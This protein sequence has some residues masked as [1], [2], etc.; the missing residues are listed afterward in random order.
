MAAA[1]HTAPGTGLASSLVEGGV[2]KKSSLTRCTSRL[3]FPA[4]RRISTPLVQFLGSH[5]GLG[6]SPQ[7]LCCLRISLCLG[8]FNRFAQEMAFAWLAAPLG[9]EEAGTMS[10]CQPGTQTILWSKTSLTHGF[11][12]PV[13]SLEEAPSTCYREHT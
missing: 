2:Q 6:Y 9:P 12:F 1:E 10:P 8:L 3:P 7:T 11:R 4:S 13:F 5:Q